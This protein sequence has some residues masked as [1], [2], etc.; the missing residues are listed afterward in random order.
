MRTMR[1]KAVAGGIVAASL[2]ALAPGAVPSALAAGSIS[3]VATNNRHEPLAGICATI[4]DA[5]T[6]TTIGGAGPTGADGTWLAND[7]PAGNAITAYINNACTQGQYV[8]EWYPGTPS[9]A[10]ATP[11]AV[12]DGQ[13]TSGINVMLPLGGSVTGKVTDMA[14]RAPLQDIAVFAFRTDSFE[15][16]TYGACTDADGKYQLNGVPTK[17]VK[18]EFIPGICADDSVHA[19]QWFKNQ[20]DYDHAT[21]IRVLPGG[22]R[23][24]VNAALVP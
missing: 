23:P 4:I 16:A 2:A 1:W 20:P 6:N 14:S 19:A 24:L 12:V 9:Q 10:N 11:F 3:G 8:G 7:I 17:G 13:T 5:A 22:N 18:V 15:S 21:V